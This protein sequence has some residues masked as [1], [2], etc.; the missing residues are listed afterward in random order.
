MDV[1]GCINLS[2]K[3]AG[4]FPL[5]KEQKDVVIKFMS[6][7]DVFVALPTG[8]GISACYGILPKARLITFMHPVTC[9]WLHLYGLLHSI[10]TN[11]SITVPQTLTF[12]DWY[13]AGPARLG[14]ILLSIIHIHYVQL[15]FFI[16]MYYSYP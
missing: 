3:V 14:Q 8:F 5:K 10:G 13:E 6:G 7:N 16:N 9:F 2:A 4:Y 12:A 1:E 11:R 15:C